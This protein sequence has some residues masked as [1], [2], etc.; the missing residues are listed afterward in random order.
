MKGRGKREIPKKTRRP[1][2]SFTCENPGIKPGS[3]KWE[4][5]GLT[6]ISPRPL[7]KKWN[8]HLKAMRPRQESQ[9]KRDSSNILL[10]SPT[11][12]LARRREN[13]WGSVTSASQS[14]CYSNIPGGKDNE[15]GPGMGEEGFTRL[16]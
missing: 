9:S 15:V 7:W 16:E 4:A 8:F 14:S 13:A 5:S 6:T 11:A 1:A 2:L 12:R 10:W 3:P